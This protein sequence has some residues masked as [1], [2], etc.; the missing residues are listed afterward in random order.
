MSKAITKKPRAPRVKAPAV[1]PPEV[2]APA[3]P[4]PAKVEESEALQPPTKPIEADVPAAPARLD[5]RHGEQR[6]RIA[7][8]LNIAKLQALPMGELN[9]M[10]RDLGVENFGTMRKHEVIFHILQ[11]NAERA[12][13]LFSEGV[14]EV[15]PEGFGFL[16]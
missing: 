8:S 11:K 13:V 4:A 12:G 5:T 2:V 9:K 1:T 6:D 14:L 15:L 7:T 16:R 10:A 3:L